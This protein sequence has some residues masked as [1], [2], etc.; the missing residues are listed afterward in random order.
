MHAISAIYLQTK[1]FCYEGNND[2]FMRIMVYTN[3][4]AWLMTTI[5]QSVQADFVSVGTHTTALL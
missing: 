1:H 4:K 5:S 3:F 2:I